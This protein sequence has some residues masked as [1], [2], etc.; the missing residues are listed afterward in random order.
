MTRAPA[1]SLARA[2]AGVAVA[3]LLA[4]AARAQSAGE[5]RSSHELWRRTC[6]YCHNDRV[7]RE[8]R[9]TGISA[10][11]LISAVRSGPGGMPSFAPSEVSDAEL[12]QLAQWIAAQRKPPAPEP[13]RSA[14]TARHGSRERPQ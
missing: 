12:E 11:L 3:C 5:W 10:P 8:L 7:A 14:R 6:G 9:G 2:L 1:S 4:T 13:D